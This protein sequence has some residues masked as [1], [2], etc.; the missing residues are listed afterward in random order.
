ML[1]WNLYTTGN[2]T[3][4]LYRILL[5]KDKGNKDPWYDFMVSNIFYGLYYADRNL[6]RFNAIGIT[7]KEYISRDYYALQTLF[8]Q[9][10]RESLRAD[11]VN[12]H[13]IPQQR[14]LERPARPGKRPE[15]IALYPRPRSR[16][17][18]TQ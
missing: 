4:C 3:P 8:E 18:G 1:I 7:P 5:E 6:D 13:L 12:W 17:F 14:F 2:L 9:I 10:P 16:R 15:R 11:I